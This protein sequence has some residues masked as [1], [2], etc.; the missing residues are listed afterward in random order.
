MFLLMTFLCLP[1]CSPVYAESAE[2]E[3]RAL[4]ARQGL[5]GVIDPSGREILPTAFEQA[6]ILSGRRI[7]VKKQGLYG[8]YDAD[9]QILIPAEYERLY[10]CAD[11]TLLLRNQ[12]G[13]WGA[14][15][16]S[17][18]E[19]LPFVYPEIYDGDNGVFCVRQEN[20]YWR[21]MREQNI[22]VDDHGYELLSSFQEGRIA[23]KANGKWGFLDYDGNF[24]VPAVYEE[25]R[26]F[27][28]GLAPVRKNG[29]WGFADTEGN[30]VIPPRFQGI[31]CG[32]REGIA[33]VQQGKKTAF[34]DRSG[35]TVFTKDISAV[36]PFQN[37]IAEVRKTKK[38]LNVLSSILYGI[39]LGM[40]HIGLPPDDILQKNEKRGYI[41]A[42]G[43]DIVPT[44][45]DAVQTCHDGVIVVKKGSHWGAF[46]TDGQRILEFKYDAL[47][48]FH[49]GLAAARQGNEW[50]LIDKQGNVKLTFPSFVQDVGEYGMGMIPFKKNSRWGYMNLQGEIVIEPVYTNVQPFGRN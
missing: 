45:Y 19:L 40:G 26:P 25:V 32:F 33:A 34:I 30:E 2:N 17:G 23:A 12:N 24:A 31:V 4:A 22:P 41:N 3:A 14:V 5:V 9:G 6:V 38:H 44:K 1:A 29:Q 8:V 16:P 27:S 37:G 10:V 15:S 39:G 43:K 49:D 50:S 46:D 48:N 47:R 28:D 7:A 13:M 20:G 21:L 36:L 18:A 35:N 42:Q 11:G